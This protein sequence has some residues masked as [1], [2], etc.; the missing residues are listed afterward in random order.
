MSSD[1]PLYDGALTGKLVGRFVRA[2]QAFDVV[3]PGFDAQGIK[4]QTWTQIVHGGVPVFEVK[5]RTDLDNVIDRF[6]ELWERHIGEDED[7]L[8]RA[9]ASVKKERTAKFRDGKSGVTPAPTVHDVRIP[10]AYSG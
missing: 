10:T 1:L 6:D 8:A 2:G 9:L 4:R 5:V 7:L 3:R